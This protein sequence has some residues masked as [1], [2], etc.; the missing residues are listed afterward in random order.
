MHSPTALLPPAA[1]RACAP[2][3]TAGLQCAVYYNDDLQVTER[4]KHNNHSF[5]SSAVHCA[6]CHCHSSPHP[7]TVHLIAGSCSRQTAPLAPCKRHKQVHTM[8][9]QSQRQS[10]P[11][12]RAGSSNMCVAGAWPLR[13]AGE[14]L[15]W[16]VPCGGGRHSAGPAHTRLPA[17]STHH[18]T[19]PLL[20]HTGAAARPANASARRRARVVRT[21]QTL[22]DAPTA[23][24]HAPGSDGRPEQAA[25]SPSTAAG[26]EDGVFSWTKAWCVRAVAGGRVPCTADNAGQR[27]SR[28]S[29]H[30]PRVAGSCP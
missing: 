6:F 4:S 9:L 5:I 14:W 21:A 10:T 17:P 12:Q 16:E 11:C 7:P 20:G 15:W 19:T 29:W 1:A 28:G 3:P 27:C 22:T 8:L 25:L 13:R 30:R 23:P 24:R 18:T 2:P 26:S